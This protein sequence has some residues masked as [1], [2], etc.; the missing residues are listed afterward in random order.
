MDWMYTNCSTTAQ[1]GA[2]DWAP[3]F[4]DT[5]KPVIEDCYQKV[6]SGEEA[7]I[8]INSNSKSDYRQ[9]LDKELNDVNNQEM[10]VAGKVL[11]QLRPEN[12]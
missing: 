1:R 2:L 4:R 3:K 10:W 12:L 11:R 6:I 8:A 7:K 5:L 9:Q